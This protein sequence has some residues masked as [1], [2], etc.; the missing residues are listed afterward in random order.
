M[1]SAYD[2]ENKTVVADAENVRRNKAGGD[3]NG[4]G[5][6]GGDD[7]PRSGQL[8]EAR[9]NGWSDTGTAVRRLTDSYEK[10][11]KTLR[12][13]RQLRDETD[14]W[15]DGRLLSAATADDGASSPDAARAA[16]ERAGRLDELRAMVTDAAGAVGLGPDDAP[17]DEVGRLSVK[18]DRV[19]G[20][21]ARLGDVAAKKNRLSDDVED[22]RRLLHDI[23]KVRAGRPPSFTRFVAAG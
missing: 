5:D 22:A 17:L 19:R 4:D 6:D 1:R 14:E 7:R 21:L 10:A 18:L 8:I 23:E 13:Y 3:G 20:V 12:G 11:A 2:R 15:L 9:L 16:D